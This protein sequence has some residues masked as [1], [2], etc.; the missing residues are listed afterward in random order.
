MMNNIRL[1]VLGLG[2]VVTLGAGPSWTAPGVPTTPPANL[3]FE[4]CWDRNPAGPVFRDIYRDTLGRHWMCAPCQT[5]T[6]TS[7]QCSF[8]SDFTLSLGW[9]SM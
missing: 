9:W 6:N 5:T 4:G 8:I 2:L 3:V 7:T 1:L